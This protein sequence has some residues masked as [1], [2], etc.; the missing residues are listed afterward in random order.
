MLGLLLIYFIGKRFYDLSD[1]HNQ[2]NWLYAILGVVIYYA[3]AMA[4]GLFLGVLILFTDV[5]VDIENN[6][7]MSAIALPFGLAAVYLFYVFLKRKW[8]KT[9]VVVKDEIQDIGKHI[10]D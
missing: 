2:N 9:V 3:G 6:L 7:L 10:E 4:A 5:E 1:I 8:E